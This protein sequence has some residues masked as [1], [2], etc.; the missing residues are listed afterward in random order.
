MPSVQLGAKTPPDQDC[1]SL[2]SVDS[3]ITAA[4]VSLFQSAN[5]LFHYVRVLGDVLLL[6]LQ[7]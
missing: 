6:T 7:P 3:I 1:V 5:D 4:G 2:L